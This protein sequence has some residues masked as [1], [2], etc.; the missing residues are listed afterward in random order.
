MLPGFVL[1]GTGFPYGL[2]ERLRSPESVAATQRLLDAEARLESLQTEF[3]HDRHPGLCDHEQRAGARP[4]TPFRALYAIAR[5]VRRR[6]SM[7][8]ALVPA[9]STGGIPRS[10]RSW[11]PG[12]RRWASTTRRTPRRARPSPARWGECGTVAQAE[13]VR[14]PRFRT[15]VW[16]SNPHMYETG[17]PS[18]IRHRDPDRRPSKIRQL[19]RRLYA[20]LQRL[21]A[22]NET[23]SF[24]GPLNYGSF[25]GAGLEYERSSEPIRD[26]R[27]FFA[28]WAA[29]ALAAEVS[30]DAAVRAHLTPRRSPLRRPE[31]LTDRLLQAVYAGCDGRR[32]QSALAADLEL[33]PEALYGALDRLSE[34]GLVRTE[35]VIPPAELDPLG[36]VI[37][38]VDALPEACP[39]RER[40]YEALLELDAARH[41]FG[42]SCLEDRQES[43][44]R[45]ERRFHG[46]TQI[47]PRRGAGPCPRSRAALRGVPRSSARAALW[48]RP[49]DATDRRDC[50]DRRPR[51]D[52]RTT[53]AGR[54]QNAARAFV[55]ELSSGRRELPFMQFIAA[56]RRRYP[57]PPPSRAADG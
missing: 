36:Y 41:Q 16:M 50:A 7:N 45:V 14:D 43:L 19:E 31:E 34:L 23:V 55:N 11:P 6:Q 8:P 24:F 13:A 49:S 17:L 48:R 20:Y 32:T 3:S 51:A 26:R 33:E 42:S 53:P 1:R 4:A 56:W 9:V 37:S 57:E 54:S 2:L 39:S 21:C 22:K 35:L 5:T 15:A 38:F 12:S 28:Y 52:D 18:F 40:W 44:A 29:S 10:Q 46:L 30:A 25:D 27:V 47:E